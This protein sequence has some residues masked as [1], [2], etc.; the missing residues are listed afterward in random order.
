[1]VSHGGPPDSL[2]NSEFFAQRGY[3]KLCF[4]AHIE[5]QAKRADPPV[6]ELQDEIGI[7]LMHQTT[8]VGTTP[9]DPKVIRRFSE[10]DE[11]KKERLR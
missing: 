11:I 5:K 2:K 10:Y 9:S 8:A 1:M 7:T 4:V 3:P 6:I